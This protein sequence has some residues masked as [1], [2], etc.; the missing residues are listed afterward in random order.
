M[1]NGFFTLRQ[2]AGDLPDTRYDTALERRYLCLQYKPVL[3]PAF[4]HNS[5]VLFAMLIGFTGSRERD[6]S[7][8]DHLQENSHAKTDFCTAYRR[9][10][11]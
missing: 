8:V 10:A 5:H 3:L 9:N 7:L 4:Y 2:I 1:V 11:L 6:R